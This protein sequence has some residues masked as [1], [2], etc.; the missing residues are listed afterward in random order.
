M[1]EVNAGERSLLLSEL[2]HKPK[3]P[4]TRDTHFF[5][6]FSATPVAYG[7]SRA[8]DQI[9]ARAATYATAAAMPNP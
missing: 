3:T 4:T 2:G 8:R 7:S 5:F 9:R 6:F 1:G